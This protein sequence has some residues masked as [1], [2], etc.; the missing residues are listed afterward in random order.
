LQNDNPDDDCDV[1]A[2]VDRHFV[3][4]DDGDHVDDEFGNVYA[5]DDGGRREACV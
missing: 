4:D 1:V 5:D 2:D 3:A